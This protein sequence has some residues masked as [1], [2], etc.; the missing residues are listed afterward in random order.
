MREFFQSSLPY[1]FDLTKHLYTKQMSSLFG[2]VC[3]DNHIFIDEK[4]LQS[5]N[6]CLWIYENWPLCSRIFI[7]SNS[8][9]FCI[10]IKRLSSRKMSTFF[11]LIFG[12]HVKLFVSKIVFSGK[13]FF[14]IFTFL[15]L[16]K[17]IKL[18]FILNGSLCLVF[19]KQ[20]FFILHLFN[21]FLIETAW[22][23]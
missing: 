4:T 17:K 7:L 21:I 3:P 11:F 13:L 19:L 5:E 15:H 8:N 6:S 23:K 10:W 20:V 16:K 1:Y 22:L 2:Y 9:S 14:F 18:L 12:L